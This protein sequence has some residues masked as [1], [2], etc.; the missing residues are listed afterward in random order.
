M[1]V[2]LLPPTRRDGEITCSLLAQSGIE[3]TV[4][5]DLRALSAAIGPDLGAVM[6]TDEAL[7]D[8]DLGAFTAAMSTQPP[9]SDIPV[10]LLTNGRDWSKLSDSRLAL[11]TNLT[12]LD[13]PASMR[14][15]TSA[16]QSALRARERQFQIRDRIADLQDAEQALRDADQ[17]KDE[18]LATLAHELRNPLAP[19]RSG[20][21]LLQRVGAQTRQARQVREMMDR[22]VNQLVKLIDELLDVSR[23]A[24]GKVVLQRETVDMRAVVQNAIEISAPLVERAGHRLSVEAQPDPVWLVGDASRLAQVVSN[25]INNAAKYTPAGGAIRVALGVEDDTAVL[26]VV[27]NGVGIPTEL[28][29]SVFEMFTQVDRTL[30]RAQGGL[31]IGLSLARRL[32]E[33]HGG[34]IEAASEGVGRGSTFTLR[35]PLSA[36]EA[37]P[38]ADET[39]E[40][41][42]T[43]RGFR[44]LIVD[45]NVDAADALAQH[46]A[47]LGHHTRTAYGGS[48]ALAVAAEFA[49][50]IVFC[51]LG[52]PKVDGFAVARAMR[53]DERYASTLLVALTGW[54][55]EDDRHRT[56]AAGFD[57]H[58][59]KPVNEETVNLLLAAHEARRRDAMT[60]GGLEV[61]PGDE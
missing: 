31:G 57:L 52:M 15:M 17:R 58:I 14:A 33:L 37:R 8:D 46:L 36:S 9:W 34:T 5:T 42:P 44:V 20:L 2:L 16:V 12:V 26:R 55:T 7:A 56:Q 4:V 1:Q 18:F 19:I 41:P 50:E 54:G 32:A 40:A 47:L 53:N 23:I 25:L 60:S 24:T 43:E 30:D 21:T 29:G 59:V 38:V 11:L 61:A 10:L 13:R 28:I 39:P 27:D 35:L 22:Q 3:C 49:P 6:L 48:E 51:D 45:D